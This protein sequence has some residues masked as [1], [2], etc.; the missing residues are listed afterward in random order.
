MLKFELNRTIL[1][2]F[3]PIVRTRPPKYVILVIWIKLAY[4]YDSSTKPYIFEPKEF[5]KS[6]F[7]YVIKIFQAFM[8]ASLFGNRIIIDCV[9]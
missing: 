5:N 3:V 4:G 6:T 7:I 9:V 8:F 1:I 2:E